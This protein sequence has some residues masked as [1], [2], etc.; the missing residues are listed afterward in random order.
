MRSSISVAKEMKMVKKKKIMST[1]V[2]EVTCDAK[3]DRGKYPSKD[4]P[5]STQATKC[6]RSSFVTGLFAISSFV[7]LLHDLW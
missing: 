1:C 7:Q 6:W 4:F 2:T 3:Q 5:E